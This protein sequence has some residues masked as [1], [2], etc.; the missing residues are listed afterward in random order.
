MKTT[1]KKI[2]YRRTCRCPRRK[3]FRTCRHSGPV[4][5]TAYEA[6]FDGQTIYF[7]RLGS[8]QQFADSGEASGL[9]ASEIYNL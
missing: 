9:Y 4:T 2:T 1:V 5:A 3:P 7:Q 8:A 6:T